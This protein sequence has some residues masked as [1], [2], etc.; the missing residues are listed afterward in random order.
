MKF[1]RLMQ[2][3]RLDVLPL[4]QSK[5]LKLSRTKHNS[6]RNLFPLMCYDAVGLL[7]EGHPACKKVGVG[8]LMVI[9]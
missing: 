5:A 4:T 3:K 8:L 7:K 9:I 1:Y 6:I 2:Q